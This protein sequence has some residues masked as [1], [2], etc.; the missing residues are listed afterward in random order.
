M[1]QLLLILTLLLGGCMFESYP[2]DHFTE[3]QKILV[4]AIQAGDLDKVKNLAP[5]TDLTLKS[6]K[7]IPIL[8]AA[9]YEAMD[10]IKSDKPTRRLQIITELVRAGAPLNQRGDFTET[11]LNMALMQEH[12]ALLEAML[13]GGLDPNYIIDGAPIIF[14]VLSNYKLGSVEALVKYGADIHVKPGAAGGMTPAQSAVVTAPKVSYYLVTVGAD[15]HAYNDFTGKT[16]AMTVFNKEKILKEGID[17]VKNG[18]AKGK[19][20]VLEGNL[21]AIQKIKAIMIEKG[22]PWPPKK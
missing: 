10:D 4:K 6:D 18:R 8:T 21:V 15:L 1:K 9:I 14:D 11:P 12:P 17:D 2:M 7:S 13:A 22:I 16:F 3:E 5:T 20:E 19:L